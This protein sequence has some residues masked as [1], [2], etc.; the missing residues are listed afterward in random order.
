MSFTD[1]NPEEFNGPFRVY[2]D[3]TSEALREKEKNGQATSIAPLQPSTLAM[4]PSWGSSKGA[5]RKRLA[6]HKGRKRS[7]FAKCISG[8]F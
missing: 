1:S 6:R 3:F 8:I 4:F 2:S 7:C 5:G